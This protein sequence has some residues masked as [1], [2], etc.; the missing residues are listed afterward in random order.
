MPSFFSSPWAHARSRRSP[1]Y[2]SYRRS[3]HRHGGARA[4]LSGG[5]GAVRHACSPAPIRGSR[6]GTDAPAYHYSDSVV[7]GFSHTHLSGTGA[8][9]YGDILL[10]PTVGAVQLVRGDEKNPETGYCSRFSHRER[11]RRAGVLP[12]HARRRRR[13]RSSSPRRS[14]RAS[15]GTP[16]RESD[17]ANVVI[18]LAHRDQT[19]ESRVTNRRTTPRSW[20]PPVPRLGGGPA[21]LLRRRSSRSPSSRAAFRRTTRSS[22]GIDEASGT[23]VKAVRASSATA[24]GR[25]DSRE[26]RHLGGRYRGRPEESRRRDSGLGFRE[27]AHRRRRGVERRPRED[28]RQGRHEGGSARPSTRRSTTR[29][30]RRTSS[31]TSTAGTGAAIS[32]IHEAKDFTNYTVFS[33]W[34]TYRAEHPLFTI[35]EPERTVGFH[36]DVPRAVRAGRA[37]ARLGARRRT[38]RTA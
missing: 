36:Q 27:D 14:A 4:H 24:D 2:T 37:A 9:D 34:D 1:L 13:D 17:N 33:L 29:C 35:I 16:S 23:N 10:M 28:R 15:T 21:R 19:I 7:Y 8:S 32:Q 38:R 31:W 25:G 12:R 5:H 30:S 3:V 22:S 6:A 20:L 18:D 26:G 11:G